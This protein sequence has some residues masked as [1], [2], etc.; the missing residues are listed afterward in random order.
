MKFSSHRLQQTQVIKS[1]QIYNFENLIIS[2]YPSG[3]RAAFEKKLEMDFA[4][5]YCLKREGEKKASS[6]LPS[7]KCIKTTSGLTKLML[8]S[9]QSTMTLWRGKS[10]Q[11]NIS[12]SQPKLLRQDQLQAQPWCCCRR[13]SVQED[14]AVRNPLETS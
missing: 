7:T 8:T 5:I 1:Q 13:Q 14:C 6:I 2:I 4:V 10:T 11:I 12:A 9:G 3:K